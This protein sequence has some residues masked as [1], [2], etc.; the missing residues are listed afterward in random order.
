MRGR[1]YPFLHELLIL[2]IHDDSS[3]TE[4]IETCSAL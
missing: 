1:N 3:N 4:R 2:D